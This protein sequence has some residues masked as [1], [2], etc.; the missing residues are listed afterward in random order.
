MTCYGEAS[1][2]EHEWSASLTG[3]TPDTHGTGSWVGS[4]AG[5]DDLEKIQSPLPARIRSLH[6]PALILVTILT[7]LSWLK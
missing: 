4:L 3:K 5:L 2:D 6:R 7:A 1:L